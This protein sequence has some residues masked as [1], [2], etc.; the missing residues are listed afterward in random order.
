MATTFTAPPHKKALIAKI[1]ETHKRL[2]YIQGD[3]KTYI[4]TG[5]NLFDELSTVVDFK[6]EDNPAVDFGFICG[7]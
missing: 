4:K 5:I 1:W 6:Y 2:E 7:C 3:G